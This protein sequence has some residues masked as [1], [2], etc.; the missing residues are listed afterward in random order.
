MQSQDDDIGDCNIFVLLMDVTL[1]L[2]ILWIE[3]DGMIY[4]DGLYSNR[5]HCM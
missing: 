3:C 1:M 5:W 2:L 4:G